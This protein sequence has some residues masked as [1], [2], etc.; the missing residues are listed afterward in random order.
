M[1]SVQE[2]AF[3]IISEQLRVPSEDVK[4]A[5]HLLDDL[6]ADSLDLVD[7]TIAIE[8]EFS[9]D[10][11]ELEISEDDAADLQTVQDVINYLARH[12]IE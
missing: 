10:D 11:R 8:E 5:A 4:P 2:R 3:A 1:P 12:G 9:D 7:L 6:K